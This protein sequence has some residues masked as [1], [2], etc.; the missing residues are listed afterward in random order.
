MNMFKFQDGIWTE[1]EQVEFEQIHEKFM[2]WSWIS[3]IRE[4]FTST[5]NKKNRVG[6]FS[7]AGFWQG[8]IIDRK[9]KEPDHPRD[10]T[11]QRTPIL[12]IK[13]DIDIPSDI[14]SEK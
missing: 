10:R 9:H 13:D 11:L 12:G 8:E 3:W 14:P 2:N 4:L 6:W 5:E 1:L 7:W